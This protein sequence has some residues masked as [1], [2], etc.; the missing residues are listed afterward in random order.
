MSRQQPRL[1]RLDELDSGR[2]YGWTGPW[3]CT[4]GEAGGAEST[5][6]RHHAEKAKAAWNRLDPDRKW[7]ITRVSGSCRADTAAL[8]L[9][10]YTRA[11]RD[12]P[13]VRSHL[14]PYYDQM[15]ILSA[16]MVWPKLADDLLAG[17]ITGEVND[18]RVLR[19]AVSLT[20]IAVPL[21]LAD[22][23]YLGED[24]ARLVRDALTEL[25]PVSDKT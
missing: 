25:L 24:S 21:N 15:G 4:C 22:L 23:Y 6:A 11:L 7:A 1:H 8:G 20:G 3:Q 2:Y 17:K 10:Y 13:G 18:L 16:Q 9:V 5:A 14:R 12:H 19:V